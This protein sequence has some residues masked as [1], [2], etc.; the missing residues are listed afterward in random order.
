MRARRARFWFELGSNS[1]RS[2]EHRY[3]RSFESVLR[4]K[5]T[6]RIAMTMALRNARI[7]QRF[8]FRK[9]SGYTPRSTTNT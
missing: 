9:T 5:S 1:I 8:Q 3:A 2:I 4:C 6:R 7:S